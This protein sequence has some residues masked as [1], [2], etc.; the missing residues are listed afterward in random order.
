MSKIRVF[1]KFYQKYDSWFVKH[2]HVYQSE[3]KA[4]D[5]FIPKNQKGIEIAP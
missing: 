1:D 2:K 4:L 3:I 5:H